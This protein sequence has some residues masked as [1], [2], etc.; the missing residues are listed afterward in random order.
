MMTTGKNLSPKVT[1]SDLHSGGGKYESCGTGNTDRQKSDIRKFG[2][3]NS[4]GVQMY[5]NETQGEINIW[6]R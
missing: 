5:V 2:Y 4:N 3:E 1:D 6:E